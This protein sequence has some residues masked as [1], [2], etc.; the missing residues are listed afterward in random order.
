MNS[1][2]TTPHHIPWFVTS[3][4]DTDVLMVVTAVF[5]LAAFLGVGILFFRL[6]SLPERM[7]HKGKKLQFEIVAVLCLV[8]LFTHI[9]WLWLAGLLLALIDIP[10][11]GGPLGRMAGSLEKIAGTAPPVAKSP[12]LHVTEMPADADEDSSSE[13]AATIPDK[14]RDSPGRRKELLRA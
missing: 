11:F 9:H 2:P 6:H 13:T 10:D 3:P 8:A 4:G 7:A 14:G 5:L 12:E 1:H